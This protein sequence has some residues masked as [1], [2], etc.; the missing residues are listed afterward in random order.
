[1]NPLLP[2][3]NLLNNH[4]RPWSLCPNL[5]FLHNLCSISSPS[6][7]QETPL[8]FSPSVQNHHFP[9]FPTAMSLPFTAVSLLPHHHRRLQESGPGLASTFLPRTLTMWAR[10]K[11]EFHVTKCLLGCQ[12]LF[13]SFLYL[14]FAPRFRCWYGKSVLAPCTGKKNGK[15]TRKMHKLKWE[16]YGTFLMDV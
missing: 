1:M 3:F 5:S 12:S 2:L 16:C 13:L 6:P 14:H 4:P 8:S 11:T 7:S 15:L 10:C 9:L